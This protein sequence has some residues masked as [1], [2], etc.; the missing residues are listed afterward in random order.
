MFIL[1]ILLCLIT[2]VFYPIIIAILSKLTPIKTTKSSEY[3]P[4]ISIIISAYNEEKHILKK[5]N[6]TLNIDYPGELFEILIGSDGSTDNTVQIIKESADSLVRFFEFT[7]NRG[8]TSVQNDLVNKAS[9][10]I[11]VFTDAASFLPEESIKELIS[12]F[13]DPKV[14]CVAGRMEFVATDDNLNTKSQGL[15]WKYEVKIRELESKL[16]SLIGVDGPLYAVRRECYV[17]LEKNIISDFITPLLVLE[18]NKY[19][20]LEKKSIIEEEPTQK[21]EQEF[22]TRRRI[23]LRGLV[24]VFSHSIL[25]NPFKHPLLCMQ[26]LCHKIIRW[27]VGPIVIVNFICCIILFVYSNSIFISA[28]LMGYILLFITAYI[29]WLLRT[30]RDVNKLFTV[31]Y[32]FI[33]VNAA[34]TYGIYDFFTRKQ[35][36]TWETQREEAEN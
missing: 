30:K 7:E 4:K 14:G 6:N 17:P 33:L 29:G 35:A 22:K 25:I 12:N 27:F 34:A 11:L 24:G 15:Y 9:G 26:I 8:K 23:T 5:I 31:P 28:V 13:Y 18:Q 1:T 16:G 36:V 20:T 19:V 2:Y 32:Y 21:S 3:K 10:D